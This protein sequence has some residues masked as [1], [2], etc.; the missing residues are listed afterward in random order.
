MNDFVVIKAH[1]AR[2]WKGDFKKG[3]LFW[4]VQNSL[5]RSGGICS[6][7]KVV[8]VPSS[9]TAYASGGIRLHGDIWLW[10]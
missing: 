8:L 3:V 6:P 5:E 4:V 10:R 1:I 2:L 7:L 9:K